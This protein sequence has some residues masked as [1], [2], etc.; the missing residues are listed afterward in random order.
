M[1]MISGQPSPSGDPSPPETLEPPF[2]HLQ[3]GPGS[4]HRATG[5]NLRAAGVTH[6][7]D[8]I[9]ISLPHGKKLK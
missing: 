8:H 4:L 9:L 1:E 3:W 6:P 7:A 2:N 5:K